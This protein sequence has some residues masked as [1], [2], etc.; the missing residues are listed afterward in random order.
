VIEA[1][2]AAPSRLAGLASNGFE[3]MRS[4]YSKEAQWD[5]FK[6]LVG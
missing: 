3:L 6:N 5:Q 2:L 1:V 4:K